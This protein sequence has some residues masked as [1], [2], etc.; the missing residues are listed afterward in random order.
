MDKSRRLYRVISAIMLLSLCLPS[1]SPAG[2]ALSSADSVGNTHK[3]A[4]KVPLG[5]ISRSVPTPRD[6]APYVAPA[7]AHPSLFVKA[8]LPTVYNVAA[9]AAQPVGPYRTTV[10]IDSATDLQRIKDMQ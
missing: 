1:V 9:E 3:G 8:D 10:S 7:D 4:S 5:S 6:F 2:A